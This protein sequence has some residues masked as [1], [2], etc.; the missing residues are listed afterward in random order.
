VQL[1][2]DD[3]QRTGCSMAMARGG[4]RVNTPPIADAGENLICCVDQVNVFDANR[5]TDPDGDRLTFTWD[6][7]DGTTAESPRAQHAYRRNGNYQV[8]LTVSD[9]TDTGCNSSTDAFLAEVNVSPVAR[10]A[11]RGEQGPIIPTTAGE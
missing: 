9:G 11:I 5:S 8:Y 3:G 10:M 4:V 1:T 6:F 7:G 2:I